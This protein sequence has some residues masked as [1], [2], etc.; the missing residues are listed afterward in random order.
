MREELGRYCRVVVVMLGSHH[1]VFVASA[2]VFFRQR[3]SS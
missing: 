1:L 2:L 3:F